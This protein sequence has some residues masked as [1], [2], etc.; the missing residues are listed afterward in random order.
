MRRKGLIKGANITHIMED[1]RRGRRC[2]CMEGL[3][4]TTHIYGDCNTH[5]HLWRLWDMW[6][7]CKSPFFSF[8]P[9]F[10]ATTS[11]QYY[12]RAHFLVSIRNYNKAIKSGIGCVYIYIYVKNVFWY[13]KKNVYVSKH[14]WCV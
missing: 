11:N 10:D 12:P 14:H 13:Y 6:E 3:G 9:H 8:G 7:T 1:L 4:I 5:T 2:V